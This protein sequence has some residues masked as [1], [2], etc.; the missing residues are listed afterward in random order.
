MHKE[1]LWYEL[2]MCFLVMVVKSFLHSFHNVCGLDVDLSVFWVFKL[3]RSS[4]NFIPHSLTA[5]SRCLLF[6]AWRGQVHL[7]FPMKGA[8]LGAYHTFTSQ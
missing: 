7:P 5:S 1:S 6:R 3:S 2:H 4:W 8:L